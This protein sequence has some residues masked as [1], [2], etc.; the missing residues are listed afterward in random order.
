MRKT[1]VLAVLVVGCGEGSARTSI[2]VPR[3]DPVARY[4]QQQ[5]Q[6]LAAATRVAADQREQGANAIT[7]MQAK[8]AADMATAQRNQAD[9]AAALHA[10]IEA[11]DLAQ[12]K[13][14]AEECAAS[15]PGRAT[16]AQ[17]Q[18][19]A[20]VDWVKRVAPRSKL[21]ESRCKIALVNTGATNVQRS[22]S[23][24]RITPEQREDMKC[25][26]G[27]PAGV[28]DQDVYVL[29]SKIERVRQGANTSEPITDVSMGPCFAGD[30]DAG[31]DTGVLS[32]DTEGIKR[33]L[34]WKP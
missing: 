14:V 34:A 15:R 12:A 24:W 25:A 30:R 28:S 33:L 32:G 10:G 17:E 7:S 3:E 6:A 13:A 26:G 18:A 31:L 29:L 16:A 2:D 5:A 1:L 4:Q 9:Q 19:Q 21:I 23:G 11:R 20:Y 8:L 22:G 27:I